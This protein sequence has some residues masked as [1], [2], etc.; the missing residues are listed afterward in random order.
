MLL[1][2]RSAIN[3]EAWEEQ[4]RDASNDKGLAK[5]ERRFFKRLA[6]TA[7]KMQ[8]ERREGHGKSPVFV[9]A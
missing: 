8:R 7:R 3:L 4:L 9:D 6:N 2:G 5:R 1:I